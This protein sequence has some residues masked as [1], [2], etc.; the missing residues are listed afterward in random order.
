M[1]LSLLLFCCLP[2]RFF[3]EKNGKAGFRDVAPLVGDVAGFG[4]NVVKRWQ[5]MG[6][7]QHQGMEDFVDLQ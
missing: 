3:R 4:W 2:L 7:S 5:C 6:F 1:D